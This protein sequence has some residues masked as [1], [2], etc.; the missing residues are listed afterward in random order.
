[1]E[2]GSR[3]ITPSTQT[4]IQGGVNTDGGLCNSGEINTDG[5]PFI[6][7]VN[8]YPP[9]NPDRADIDQL[10]RYTAST[11]LLLQD[12]ASFSVGSTPVKV[13]RSAVET[14]HTMAASGSVI[15]TG[16]PGIGKSGVL[17]DWLHRLDDTQT[18]YLFLAAA[19]ITAHDSAQVRIPATISQDLADLLLKWPGVE[20]AYLVIDALDGVKDNR[21]ADTL[22]NLIK[23]LLQRSSRWRVVVSIREFD[24][25]HH[26]ELRTLFK[27]QPA[28]STYLK[29]YPNVRHIYVNE[30]S[31][32]ELHQ[33]AIQ[34]PQLAAL[35]LQQASPLADLL[36]VPFNLR[37]AAELL[38]AGVV[39][40]ELSPIQ[41]QIELLDRFWRIRVLQLNDKANARELLL[42]LLLKS[43]WPE[44][45]K[46]AHQI[47]K[48][49]R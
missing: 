44:T 19:N 48:V 24:L 37:L 4:N 35:L 28:Q 9:T 6:Y 29:E 49:Y 23:R 45:R 42:R 41:S 16:A 11:R 38:D 20:P 27:G 43:G 15:I 30:F 21:T 17:L 40:G 2:S 12:T 25:E 46:L 3:P 10:K 7:T 47:S 18:D 22:V 14:L 13:E 26:N 8:N 36:K 31:R 34:V 1:M 5:G 39:L 32:A 33:V